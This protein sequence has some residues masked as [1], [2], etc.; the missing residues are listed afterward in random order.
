MNR[1]ILIAALSTISYAEFEPVLQSLHAGR[2]APVVAGRAA[3]ELPSEAF[4][5]KW[6]AEIIGQYG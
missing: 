2:V 4:S 6:K 3:Y 5:E 1:P